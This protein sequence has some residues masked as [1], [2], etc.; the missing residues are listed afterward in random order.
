[1]KKPNLIEAQHDLHRSLPGYGSAQE[2][3]RVFDVDEKKFVDPTERGL[4]IDLD[5]IEEFVTEQGGN[6]DHF[7]YPTIGLYG[8]NSHY[9]EIPGTPKHTIR[10]GFV[11][12]SLVITEN[13]G[14][15]R[16]PNIGLA[17]GEDIS[18]SA[19]NHT[20][21]HELGHLLSP[22]RTPLYNRP[23][24]TTRLRMGTYAITSA[25]LT[26]L[27]NTLSGENL[28]YLHFVEGYSALDL[29]AVVL[30]T[31]AAALAGVA[32]TGAMLRN[33]YGMLASRDKGERQADAF[34]DKHADFNPI[35]LTEPLVSSIDDE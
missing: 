18:E 20:L 31:G 34:A 14:G 8:P 22:E 17:Y 5:S 6:P 33:Q 7:K 24:L 10:A 1:M 16:F 32:L 28:R 3:I 30:G 11:N 2:G 27:P 29:G 15:I 21:R 9:R 23:K 12:K 35:K 25:L 26:T 4:S 19:I 13:E